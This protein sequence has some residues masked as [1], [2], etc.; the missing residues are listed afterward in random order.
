MTPFEAL[1]NV[2]HKNQGCFG[3]LWIAEVSGDVS[4][5]RKR[6]GIVLGMSLCSV[7]WQHEVRFVSSEHP[8]VEIL[9]VTCMKEKMEADRQKVQQ[10]DSYFVPL[11]IIYLPCL[12]SLLCLRHICKA[13]DKY[14]SGMEALVSQPHWVQNHGK[15]HIFC[16]GTSWSSLV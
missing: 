8:F 7:E 16:R 12:P 5:P 13:L 1:R 3:S 15:Y 11:S 4:T 14:P 2:C 6:K 10:C 9:V